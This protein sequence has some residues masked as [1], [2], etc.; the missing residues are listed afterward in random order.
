MYNR[1]TNPEQRLLEYI[2]KRMRVNTFVDVG[3]NTGE[4]SNNVINMFSPSVHV[5][6]EP[7]PSLCKEYKFDD[8][9]IVVNSAVDIEPGTSKFYVIEREI[10]M[11]SLH[12]RNGVFDKFAHH[13]IEVSKIRFDT[14]LDEHNITE[15]DFVKIDTEGHEI[16]VMESM[17]AYLID[18]KIKLIQFE[19]GGCWV[20]SNKELSDLKDLINNLPYTACSFS[21]KFVPFTHFDRKVQQSDFTNYYLIRNDILQEIN[22]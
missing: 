7:I 8:H 16:T 18:A 10:G 14:V 20:D 21:G 12:Y 2:S 11:S 4:Y 5:I 15:V 9:V 1:V 17:G 13:E 19:Y 22:K 3:G 6:F